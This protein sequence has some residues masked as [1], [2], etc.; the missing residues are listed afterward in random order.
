MKII[1]IDGI[2]QYAPENAAET[3]KLAKMVLEG[4]VMPD[5]TDMHTTEE[6]KHKA[7]ISFK[8]GPGSGHHGHRGRPGKVGGGLPDIATAGP[9]RLLMSLMGNAKNWRI[10][11]SDYRKGVSDSYKVH[12][13]GD[14]QAIVK[15]G[16]N[17][18][19]DYDK[20]DPYKERDTYLLAKELGFDNIVPVGSSA[21]IED[22]GK[23]ASV[24]QW[25]SGDVLMLHSISI[26]KTEEIMQKYGH[27][28]KDTKVDIES[29]Q[30]V[31]F[32]GSL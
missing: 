19:S 11:E 5:L 3:R 29:F 18:Y 10:T 12:V 14:G 27:E 22:T 13:F 21:Y 15:E 26:S 17:E 30:Q 7:I 23:H 8:G 9:D 16:T 32:I 1:E 24:Q 28:L 31:A 6:I 25:V 20:N 2:T 4:K